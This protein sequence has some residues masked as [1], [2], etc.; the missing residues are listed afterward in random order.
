MTKTKPSLYVCIS[1][2]DHFFY[3]FFFILWCRDAMN[4]MATVTI[5][6]FD[7]WLCLDVSPSGQ[8]MP[9]I[10]RWAVWESNVTGGGGIRTEQRQYM[11]SK[12]VT[13]YRAETQILCWYNRD[14]RTPNSH[15]PVD[16][17]E[18]LLYWMSWEMFTSYLASYSLVVFA[19]AIAHI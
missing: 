3:L 19:K 17:W 8:C 16:F 13:V 15:C 4:S 2:V 11:P 14:T 6:H 5:G 10:R 18:T 1:F 12:Y 7:S 9:G